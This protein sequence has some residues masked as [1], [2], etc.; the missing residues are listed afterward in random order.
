ML[1]KTFGNVFFFYERQF[2]RCTINR[3]SHAFPN[4]H[5]NIANGT[6]IL[7]LSIWLAVSWMQCSLQ[8]T[9]EETSLALCLSCMHR[10]LPRTN[11]YISVLCTY[12]TQP[13]VASVCCSA[14]SFSNL[15]KNWKGQVFLCGALRSYLYFRNTLLIFMIFGN[16]Y[17]RAVVVGIFA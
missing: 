17:G 1:S 10:A 5:N 7:K 3:L 16:K 11:L 6:L 14:K 13:E 8:E 15:R 2:S 12:A 4:T 9:S